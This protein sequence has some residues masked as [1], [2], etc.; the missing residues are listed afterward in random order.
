MI[1]CRL[2]RVV[3]C[4]VTLYIRLAPFDLKLYISF[5][6]DSKAVLY[7]YAKYYMCQVL[8]Y[9]SYV[10]L[11]VQMRARLCTQRP[12]GAALHIEL[13]SSALS[14][15]LNGLRALCALWVVPHTARPR[16][17]VDTS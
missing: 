16:G 3:S 5:S 4:R 11:C 14:V 17:T 13:R 7:Y 2:G 15:N 12:K 1:A 6:R 9:L 8:P 10:R